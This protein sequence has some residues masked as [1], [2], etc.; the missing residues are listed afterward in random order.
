MN[1]VRLCACAF[2]ALLG[3]AQ[4][5][6]ADWLLTPFAG[7]AIRTQT[8]FFDLDGVAGRRHATYGVSLTWFPERVFGVDVETSWTPSAF[9]G[10]DLVE[11]S[12]V[13]T[14]MGSVV[15]ALPRRWSRAVRPYATI[16]AG[17]IQVT[18]TDIAGI[19]PIDA[20]RPAASVGVGAWW[21][22]TPRLGARIE[23]RFLRTGS[24]PASS[25][26]RWHTTAGATIR[27]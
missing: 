4:P 7:A 15:V 25:F 23:A 26:E 3:S 17:L 24:D 6:R 20:T 21:P 2:V 22:I 8:G 14:A 9:T 11:S 12:R 18:S 19:F 13:L 1:S 10:R 5:A 16:G 27:F